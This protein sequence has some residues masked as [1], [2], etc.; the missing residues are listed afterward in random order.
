MRKN[1]QRISKNTFRQAVILTPEVQNCF[2]SG[3]NAIPNKDQSK[4]E[5]VEPRKCGGS[6]FIDQCLTNQGLYQNDNRWDYAIDYNGEV[7]FFEVHTANTGE[8]STVLNKLAWLKDWLN[9][10]APEINALKAKAKTPFYWVQ[11]NGYHITRN[12]RQERAVLQKGIKPIS[13]LVL[14]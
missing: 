7:F 4:I 2:C 8:V 9:N 3:K 6:L 10:K 14:K 1:N 11:S 12:S 13:K 5:L